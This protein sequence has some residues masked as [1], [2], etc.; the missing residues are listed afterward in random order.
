VTRAEE[1]K[2]LSINIKAA[3][4]S[5]RRLNLATSAYILSMVLV[6]VSQALNAIVEDE[7]REDDAAP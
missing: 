5:A 3:I 7:N 1:L 4:D 2:E 6:D